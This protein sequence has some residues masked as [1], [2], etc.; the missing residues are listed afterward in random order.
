MSKFHFFL[1]FLNILT[2][3]N[4]GRVVETDYV[5]L[6]LGT[7]ENQLSCLEVYLGKR[8]DGTRDPSLHKPRHI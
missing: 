1:K 2:L 7:K 8:V 4:E 5:K 3:K 6:R